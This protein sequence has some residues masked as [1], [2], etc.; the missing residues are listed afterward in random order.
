VESIISMRF[1]V[2][3]F[4]KNNINTRKDLADLCNH[5]SIDPKINIKGNLKRTRA[6]YCLKP[7]ERKEILR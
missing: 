5:P 2:V 3:S 4:S 1:D 6:P 7:I